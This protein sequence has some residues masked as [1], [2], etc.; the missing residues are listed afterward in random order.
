MNVNDQNRS[1][2]ASPREA[3]VCPSRQTLRFAQGDKT[4]PILVVKNH[5]RLVSFIAPTASAE[6]RIR[7]MMKGLSNPSA[8]VAIGGMDWCR[9]QAVSRASNQTCSRV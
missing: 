6:P 2:H 9:F 5:Y 7:R 3:S 1:C 4:L 8:A